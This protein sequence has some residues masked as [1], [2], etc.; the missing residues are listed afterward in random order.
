[1]TLTRKESYVVFVAVDGETRKLGEFQSAATSICQTF[2]TYL[3]HDPVDLNAPP[4]T[5]RI[6]R[7]K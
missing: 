2:M 5:I 3:Q 6:E 7:H 4:P 1:M